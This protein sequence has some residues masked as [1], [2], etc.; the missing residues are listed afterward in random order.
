MKVF[1]IIFGVCLDNLLSRFTATTFF[2]KV[3]I[4]RFV[5]IKITL[6]YADLYLQQPTCSEVSP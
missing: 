6:S 3:Y 1:L 4:V 5:L 2:L